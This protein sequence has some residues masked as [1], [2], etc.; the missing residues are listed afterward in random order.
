M[1]RILYFDCFSGIS[2]DMALAA[3]IDLGLDADNVGAELERLDIGGYR[4][5]VEKICRNGIQGTDVTVFLEGTPHTGHGHDEHGLHAHSHD[6]ERNFEAI[7]RIIENSSLSERVKRK[8]VGIFREIA[9]SEAAVH[10]KTIDE[11]HFHEVGAVDSIVDIVG[12]AI[13]LEMLDVDSVCCSVVHEGTGF[14][15]CRHG[16]LPVPVPAVAHMLQGSG[17]RLAIDDVAGELVTPTGL[18][19]LKAHV[20]GSVPMPQMILEKVGYG[21]GKR[22]TGKLNALRV[23]LGNT[24]ETPEALDSPG[25]KGAGPDGVKTND[26]GQTANPDVVAVI[27]ANLDDMTGEMMGYA[28]DLLL[29]EGALDVF[30]TQIQMKKNRPAVILTAICR[31]SDA[32]GIA[33]LFLRETTT[34]GVRI[35]TER[36][37]VMDRSIEAIDTEFGSIRMKTAVYGGIRKT[38]PEYEDCARAAKDTGLPLFE[39][40]RRLSGPK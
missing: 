14:I 26:A 9:V 20:A 4:F 8:A 39:I 29:A 35:R 25:K 34:L 31:E 23:F 11:V 32:S 3:L 18:G 7:R 2:G 15:E 13:C 22:D 17:I 24:A 10:G 40:F 1:G 6:G 16:I 37:I 28:M 27:E 30:F 38:S 12:V 19:I 36:R 21:F 5:S 33:E